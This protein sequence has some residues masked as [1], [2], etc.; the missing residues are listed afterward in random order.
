MCVNT[1]GG[2]YCRC[3][4][5]YQ[6]NGTTC[7]DINEC[8]TNK[9]NCHAAAVCTN[10]IGSFSCACNSGLTGD[11]VH[12]EDILECNFQAGLYPCHAK[13]KCTEV[14][15]SY[16]CE[17]N[18]GYTGDGKDCDD[19]NECDTDTDDCDTNAL[20]FNTQPGFVCQCKTGFTGNGTSCS[21]IL[22]CDAGLDNCHKDA[23]CINTVG[24]FTC[25]CKDGFNGNGT[26]CYVAQVSFVKNA[27]V[28]TEGG[29]VDVTISLSGA[30]D[31]PVAVSIA[32]GG[33]AT[34]TV[35]YTTSSAAV[36]FQVNGP[37]TKTVTIT[38]KNDTKLEATET[39]TLTL[40][41]QSNHVVPGGI[42]TTIVTIADNDA[43]T[44]TL[45]TSTY[46]VDE[47]NGFAPVVVQI[48]SGTVEREIIV[49]VTTVSS[50][51]ATSN[52]DYTPHTEEIRFSPGNVGPKL[53]R[54]PITN[55]NLTESNE[56]FTV[57]LSTTDNDVN[58]LTKTAT[59]VIED[60]DVATVKFEK[61]RYP[62]VGEGDGG[63][64]VKVLLNGSLAISVTARLT[65]T[66]A[67]AV[68][69][70]DYEL[71][72]NL[73]VTFVPN[74]PTTTSITFT[75]LQDTIVENDENFLVTLSSQSSPSLIVVTPTTTAITIIDDDVLSVSFVPKIYP[76]Q[77]QNTDV[78]VNVVVTGTFE[79]SLVLSISTVDN[80]AK[81]GADYV[82]LVATPLI[83]NI[84]DPKEKEISVQ[85]TEDVHIEGTESFYVQMSSSDAKITFPN[86]TQAQ[87]NI[88]D[89][90][91]AT[92]FIPAASYIFQ[93][94]ATSSNIS[95]ILTGSLAIPVTV[96]LSTVHDTARWPSDFT[97]I[98]NFEIE[99]TPSGLK[100]KTLMLDIKND[101]VV[102]GTERFYVDLTTTSSYVSIGTYNRT[103]VL[104][105]DN[106]ELHVRFSSTHYTADENLRYAQVGLVLDKVLETSA[107]VTLTP[108]NGTATTPEDFPLIIYNITIYP[109][110]PRT[111]YYKINIT[112]DMLEEYSEHFFVSLKAPLSNNVK[113]AQPDV[114]NIT[115]AESD[116]IDFCDPNARRYPCHIKADCVDVPGSFVC[117]CITGYQ[118]N[119]LDCQ[120]TNE[121]NTIVCPFN[122]TC[123]DTVGSYK[124]VCQ[125]GYIGD[126]V[127][128]KDINECAD[129]TDNCHANATCTNTLGS[130]DCQCNN[131]YRED[132]KV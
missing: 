30:I 76:T 45:S 126:G 86:G 37:T 58:L 95:V 6:W 64:T 70:K 122:A 75:I 7:V 2:Y 10:T 63:V 128:C 114:A 48:N 44:V 89:D 112:D 34:E 81:A 115:I 92:A 26:Y 17:C 84:G 29:N 96:S 79:K 117:T 56:Q 82:S 18:A 130:F 116:D 50:G 4:T 46:N 77:E 111:V 67:G 93:E 113:I 97:A 120:N 49:S 71:P 99:F 41:S 20:C 132:G 35:D 129:K 127:D 47:G 110:Q 55:D 61:S 131:G 27:H 9:H 57:V 109:G 80:T 38:T 119:G 14:F 3:E 53:V 28:V 100:T 123:Q 74:G 105:Q 72:G 91:V 124:C 118:G 94:G 36:L 102:E 121:C 31:S 51:S 107:M 16:R 62:A 68:R 88:V 59:V 8:T 33:T 101:D 39:I 1:I 15:G 52:V 22:E 32:L 5:G 104:I 19:I 54:I 106:D 42:I 65:A 23:N 90:D 125:P 11:G 40:S 83:F 66:N 43:V 24:S 85:I 103:S 98:S 12:C 25:D 69:D 73:D 13:A 108:F 87:I 78:K 21:D 60:N